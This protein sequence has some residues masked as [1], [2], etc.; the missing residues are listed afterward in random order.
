MHLVPLTS[1]T[2]IPLLTDQVVWKHS[3]IRCS[4]ALGS[5]WTRIKSFRS[6]VRVWYRERREYILW[7]MAV[8]LPNTTACINATDRGKK[9]DKNTIVSQFTT[10]VQ[11]EI[12]WYTSS[13]NCMFPRNISSFFWWW[14]TK[15]LLRCFKCF[16]PLILCAV[17]RFNSILINFNV[18]PNIPFHLIQTTLSV[19]YWLAKSLGSSTTYLFKQA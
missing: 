13:L 10:L 4:R 18:W 16:I 2:S 1:L 17:T 6:L 14:C 3:I 12:S 8:T 7:M 15:F 19:R 9:R 5:R 11:I